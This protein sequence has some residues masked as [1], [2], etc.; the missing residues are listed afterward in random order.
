LATLQNDVPYDFEFRSEKKK[1]LKMETAQIIVS[2]SFD[3][4]L[5]T[6]IVGAIENLALRAWPL[7]AALARATWR[8]AARIWNRFVERGRNDIHRANPQNEG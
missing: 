8:V 3:R 1:K 5:V 6:I 2:R 4:F 7:A